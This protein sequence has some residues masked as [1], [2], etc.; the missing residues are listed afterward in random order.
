MLKEFGILSKLMIVGAGLF[1]GGLASLALVPEEAVYG[2]LN[3]PQQF[4]GTVLAHLSLLG[5]MVG[6]W[7][8][9]VV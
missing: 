6:D 9:S 4:V 5:G 7:L 1:L 8:R 3:D 2:L